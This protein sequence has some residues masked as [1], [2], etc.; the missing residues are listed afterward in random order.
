[1]RKLIVSILSVHRAIDYETFCVR[2]TLNQILNRRNIMV[3]VYLKNEIEREKK[4][5]I[6]QNN[7]VQ[8]QYNSR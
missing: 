2:T 7:I 4:G 1:M 3:R 5:K 6:K 8:N